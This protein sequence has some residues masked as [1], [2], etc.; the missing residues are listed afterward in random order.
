MKA[1]LL[2]SIRKISAEYKYSIRKSKQRA[3]MIYECC[4]KNKTAAENIIS[5][6]AEK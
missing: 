3:V 4:S 2:M 5:A 6:A 1:K